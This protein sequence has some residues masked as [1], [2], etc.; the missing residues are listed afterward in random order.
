MEVGDVV[1]TGDVLIDLEAMKMHTHI[2]SEVD[3]KVA[4]IIAEPG[5]SVDVG[6]RLML[7]SIGPHAT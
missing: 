5:D 7:I 4:D 6:D 2:I 3:G 1:L